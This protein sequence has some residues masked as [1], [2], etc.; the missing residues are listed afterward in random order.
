MRC[1]D[2][3]QLPMRPFK[4]NAPATD[5]LVSTS[6]GE[7]LAVTAR[8]I[9]CPGTADGACASRGTCSAATGTRILLRCEVND[10]MFRASSNCSRGR[11]CA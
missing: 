2:K 10:F 6:N 1:L 4:C 9:C 11:V 3:L 5:S 8:D 7:D